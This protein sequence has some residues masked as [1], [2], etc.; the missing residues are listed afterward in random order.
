MVHNCLNHHPR[1]STRSLPPCTG[2]R[3][4]AAT[5]YWARRAIRH[6]SRLL[7]IHHQL[8]MHHQS[9]GTLQSETVLDNL[10]MTVVWLAQ[11]AVPWEGLHRNISRLIGCLDWASRAM[12]MSFE[13]LFQSSLC[14]GWP[15]VVFSCG[16]FPHNAS[17]YQPKHCFHLAR[18]QDLHFERGVEINRPFESCL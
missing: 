5:C 4:L 14:L 7:R 8:R 3:Q 18:Q 2:S 15:L 17:N 10:W 1:A 11:S 13:C 16:E 6:Q 9:L 12:Q